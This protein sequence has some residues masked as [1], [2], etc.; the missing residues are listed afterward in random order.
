[1]KIVFSRL[2]DTLTRLVPDAGQR[3]DVL[4]T[5]MALA[6]SR[7]TSIP[8]GPVPSP[9]AYYNTQVMPG[10]DEALAKMNEHMVFDMK[11]ARNETRQFWLL[12]YAA[13]HP[14]VLPVVS[15]IGFIDTICGAGVYMDQDLICFCNEHKEPILRLS[16]DIIGLIESENQKV[17]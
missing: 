5:S 7:T 12:R 3:L 16:S 6:H 4:T 11:C 1:M 13:A 10:V 8:S 14:V 2:Q 17:A 9:A 15:A